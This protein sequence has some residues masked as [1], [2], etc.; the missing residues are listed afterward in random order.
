VAIELVAGLRVVFGVRT[1]IESNQQV[2]SQRDYLP[3]LDLFSINQ[4][5]QQITILF[6]GTMK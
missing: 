6:S 3:S 5:K 4:A 2:Q 1:V